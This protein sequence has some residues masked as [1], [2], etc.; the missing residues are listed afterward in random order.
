MLE[1]IERKTDASSIGAFETILGKWLWEWA[2]GVLSLNSYTV[3]SRFAT[4]RFMMIHLY[5]PCQ[6]G[7]S[8]PDL[9]CVTVATQASF[10]VR[11]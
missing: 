4:V 5:D 6:V 10:L 8:T 7:P 2:G 1:S 9:W 11:F 3:G